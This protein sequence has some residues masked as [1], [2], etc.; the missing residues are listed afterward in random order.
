MDDAAL[1]GSFTLDSPLPLLIGGGS[2][3]ETSVSPSTLLASAGLI[4]QKSRTL[5]YQN[6]ICP[7][8][9]IPSEL[10][11]AAFMQRDI[12]LAF[13]YASDTRNRLSITAICQDRKVRVHLKNPSLNC[14]GQVDGSEV[15]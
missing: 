8:H 1:R 11:S 10:G 2:N 6:K 14:N 5:R 9:C 4:A 12:F 3:L 15:L 7:M 13:M